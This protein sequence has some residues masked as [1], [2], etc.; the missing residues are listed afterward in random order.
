MNSSASVEHA[1]ISQTNSFDPPSQGSLFKQIR[2]SSPFVDRSLP[3]PR[4]TLSP[5]APHRNIGPAEN[6]FVAYIAF[7]EGW[8]NYHHMFPSDYRA[9]EIGGNR[10]NPT[11]RV[12]DM[13]AKLGWAYDLREPSES[14]VRA[15]I[16]NRGD[17]THQKAAEI[18]EGMRQKQAA[19]T[20]KA[21]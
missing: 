4:S 14:L 10:H 8:H 17:G 5:A 20:S 7:G 11:T 9:A 16:A 12:I 3:A 13:F 1:K 18:A 6:A 21:D 2:P 19:A 15:T